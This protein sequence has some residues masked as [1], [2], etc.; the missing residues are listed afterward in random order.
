MNISIEVKSR[1]VKTRLC[2]I[3]LNPV[4]FLF[5]QPS[6]FE[7]IQVRV[8]RFLGCIGGLGHFLVP[9]VDLLQLTGTGGLAWDPIDRVKFTLPFRQDK[10][11]IWLGTSFLVV[12][13]LY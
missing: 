9:E 4:N 11:D 5:T 8:Q 6:P 2:P 1:V 12:T 13:K 10:P 3:E 7:L